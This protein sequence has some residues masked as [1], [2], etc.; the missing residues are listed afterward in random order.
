MLSRKAIKYRIYPTKSQERL[1]NNNLEGCRL[2]YNKMLEQRKEGWENNKQSFSCY[3]QQ[4]YF[5][6]WLDKNQ[7]NIHSQVQQN[8]AVRIDLAYKAFFR[9]LKNGE[10]PGYPRFKG[11]ERYDS[12]T[13]PQTG[14]KVFED[15]IHLTKIGKVKAVIHQKID[16]NIKTC[17]V[18][19]EGNDWY[20][21][22]SVELETKQYNSETEES[23]GIDVGLKSF[24]VYSDETIIDNPRFFKA[25]EK[26][27]AKL[28]QRKEKATGN[29]KKKIVKA[30]QKRH[31]KVKNKRKDFCHKLSRNIVNKYKT[32][33][34]ED[35]DINQMKE[36]NKYISK[37]VHDASWRLFMDLLS[38]K[39]EDAGRIF[40]KVN[41]A[42]TTQDC[43]EC[44]YRLKKKLSDRVHNCP[45]C[46]LVIDRDL[47]ASK[48]ILRIGLY[49]LEQS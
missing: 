47:N 43:S 37:S 21:I 38:Y 33:C 41:P 45:N 32:I 29:R 1:L 39:A 30:I 11:Y 4:K 42:Y 6:H 49:S 40:T 13:Y 3:E 9:R 35:L 34:V 15:K 7:F 8:V 23:I 19:K 28:Q 36:E 2:L 24:A 31:K 27:I 22:F 25:E 18:K 12:F 48:N 26:K 20:V 46:E 10:K 16:G 44:G 5:R 14:W 17:T